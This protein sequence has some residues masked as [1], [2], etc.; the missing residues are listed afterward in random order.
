MVNN[1]HKNTDEEMAALYFGRAAGKKYLFKEK[2]TNK[3]LESN[4]EHEFG[5]NLE[6][7][8]VKEPRV[9]YFAIDFD[10]AIDFTTMCAEKEKALSFIKAFPS[11]KGII[12]MV[13][14]VE[15]DDD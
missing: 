6:Y 15:N 8:E 7:K 14:E 9:L 11:F 12:K 3:W 1:M 2:V 5:I 10:G 4:E 13:E